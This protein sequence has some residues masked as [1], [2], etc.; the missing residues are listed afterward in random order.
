M[1]AAWAT[2]AEA[3]ALPVVGDAEAPLVAAEADAAAGDGAVDAELAGG[4]EATE[5]V[6]ALAG[7][8]E[9]PHAWSKTETDARPVSPRPVARKRL[10]LKPGLA[11]NGSELSAMG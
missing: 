2:D 7:A 10:R 5:L 11:L 8:E 3:E 1:L 4:P 6:D 9:P